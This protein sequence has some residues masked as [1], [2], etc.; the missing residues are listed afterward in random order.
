[1]GTKQR[2]ADWFKASSHARRRTPIPAVRLVQK[3]ALGAGEVIEGR[4]WK[5]A[6]LFFPRSHGMWRMSTPECL[7]F[8]ALVAVLVAFALVLA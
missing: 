2:N 4:V 7:V 8:I 3:W 6:A 1:M 5:R